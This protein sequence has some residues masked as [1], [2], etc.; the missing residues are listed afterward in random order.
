[1]IRGKRELL[2]HCVYWGGG[3]FLLDRLPARDTLLVLNYHRIGKPDDDLFDPG[4]FSA[5]GD[6]LDEQIS[7]LK[8][9]LSL[10]SLDEAQ[11]FV[12]G[13]LREKAPRCHV[14]ITFDD[15][16]L[17]NYEIAFPILRS[18]G[19]QGVFFLATSL[20]GT[21]SVPWWDHIAF[22]MKTARQRR[23]SLRYPV[24]L[25]VDLNGEL[26][27]DSIRSVLSLYKSPENAEPERFIQELKESAQG[28]DLPRTLRRFLNWGEAQDM[29]RG[30]MAIGSHTHMHRVLSQLSMEEQ[31]RELNDSRVLLKEN[32]GIN[33]EAIAYPVGC[34]TCFSEQTQALAK[35]SGY[36]TA[37]SF[38]GGTNLP[39]QSACYDVKRIGVDSVGRSRFQTQS[40]I[41]RVT[42]KYWP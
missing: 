13:K 35:E 25:G 42:G 41:C 40:A 18:H 21:C 20:V 8:R 24:A 29:I 14:L 19:V 10:V 39:S 15:G 4:V 22:L 17:D 3:A 32:L 33:A 31:R 37:F 16:Y 7:F 2:A 27:A 11:A 9:H 34:R 38:Y 26:M 1:M 6:Q 28:E 36:R 23:F 5:T 30:G 12:E